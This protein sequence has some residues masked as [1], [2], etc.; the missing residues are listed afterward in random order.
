[1]GK[2]HKRRD[3][4][5]NNQSDSSSPHAAMYLI[6]TVLLSA[7]GG[8]LLG[9]LLTFGALRRSSPEATADATQSIPTLA[10]LVMMTPERLGEQDIAVMNLRCAEGLPGA[11]KL[12]IDK[13][14]DQLDCRVAR[15]HSRNRLIIW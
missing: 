8:C 12:D 7:F 4:H 14:L 6:T 11:E 13:C 3:R 1:L 5:R 2:K 9:A 10:E 15:V